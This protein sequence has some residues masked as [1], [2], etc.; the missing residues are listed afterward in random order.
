MSVENLRGGLPAESIRHYT[1]AVVHLSFSPCGFHHAGSS[2][3][4]GSVAYYT[5]PA[6]VGNRLSMFKPV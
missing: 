2:K 1:S 5:Y 3:G 6:T 4:C